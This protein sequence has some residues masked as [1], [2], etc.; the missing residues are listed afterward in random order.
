MRYIENESGAVTIE[1]VALTAGGLLLGVALVWA[2][3]SKGVDP[4]ASDISANLSSVE[5]VTTG[6]APDLNA[7]T[8]T[9][10]HSN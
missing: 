5:V 1:W 8:A 2:I 10:G 7:S 6:D 9:A 3:F 4:L